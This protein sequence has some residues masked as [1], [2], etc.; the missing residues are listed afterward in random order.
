[1]TVDAPN[2]K[3]SF[4]SYQPKLD[5]LALYVDDRGAFVPA[6][7]TRLKALVTLSGLP[8]EE[9]LTVGPITMSDR[10][11]VEYNATQGIDAVRGAFVVLGWLLVLAGLGLG[12]YSLMLRSSNAQESDT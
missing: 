2:R 4:G 8:A 5:Q 3:Y 11:H 9:S 7:L 6:P 10:F 12:G 1:M